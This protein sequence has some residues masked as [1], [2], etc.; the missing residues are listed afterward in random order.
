MANPQRDRVYLYVIY[1][2]FFLNPLSR[3]KPL[4]WLSAALKRGVQEMGAQWSRRYALV[5]YSVCIRK[6]LGG[7]AGIVESCKTHCNK[8]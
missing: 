5:L 2:L 7:K 8:L 6:A 3:H 4:A 1:F